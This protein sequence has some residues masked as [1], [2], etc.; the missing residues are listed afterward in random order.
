MIEDLEFLYELRSCL[1]LCRLAYKEN[2]AK[3]FCVL[4]MVVSFLFYYST[5]IVLVYLEN[6]S[7]KANNGASL[8]LTVLA[9]SPITIKIFKRI[10]RLQLN[11]F[12]AIS[13]YFSLIFQDKNG[14]TYMENMLN[15]EKIIIIEHNSFNNRNMSIFFSIFS[16]L[17]RS[18]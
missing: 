12:G 18:D 5:K 10:L 7:C 2:A 13:F 1:S 6:T 15:A 17:G 16:I 3:Y 14:S 9:L 4:S 11:T 8:R